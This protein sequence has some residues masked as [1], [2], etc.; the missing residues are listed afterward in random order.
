M[1][2]TVEDGALIFDA[3]AG[4]DPTDPATSTVPPDDYPSRLNSGVRGLRI[5][6]VPGYFF[7]HLQ[8]DVKRAVEQALTTFEDL[9]AQ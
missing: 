9:G 2:R 3:I 1:T 6:V 5:G 8:A 4:P 7:F